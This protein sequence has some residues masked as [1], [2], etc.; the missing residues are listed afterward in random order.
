MPSRLT[1][2]LSTLW[3][4]WQKILAALFCYS[5][6]IGLRARSPPALPPIL[7]RR[8]DLRKRAH[9]FTLP[10]KDD[11]QC[12]LFHVSYIEPRFL[13]FSL[14]LISPHQSMLLQTSYSFH[15]II[16]ISRSLSSSASGSRG[17][18]R[19]SGLKSGGS[20]SRVKKIRF[21]QANFRK[22]W[23]SSGN[24]TKQFRFS[25]QISK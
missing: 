21:F 2:L 14:G 17:Q 12:R 22:L 16:S 7:A 5:Q 11:K 20:W 23:V 25:R 9:P 24:F 13:L 3:L 10:L 15:N 8:P 18:R 6:L 1:V 4:I 19:Q